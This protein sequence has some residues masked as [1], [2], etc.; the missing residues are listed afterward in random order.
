MS[1]NRGKSRSTG[2]TGGRELTDLVSTIGPP[3][4]P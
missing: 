1:G 2:T 4:L 3:G